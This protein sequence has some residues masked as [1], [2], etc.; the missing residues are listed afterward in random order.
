MNRCLRTVVALFF[1][2]KSPAA[3]RPSH[4]RALAWLRTIVAA[5]TPAI[6]MLPQ[7]A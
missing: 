6:L 5:I 1:C 2:G 4:P 7:P 3:R